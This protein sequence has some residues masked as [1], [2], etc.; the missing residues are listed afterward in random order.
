MKKIM[1]L[2]NFIKGKR[3]ETHHY[4]LR[5]NF[6]LCQRHFFIKI[7]TADMWR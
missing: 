5:S 3:K 4:G 2:K 1:I 6:K 7:F